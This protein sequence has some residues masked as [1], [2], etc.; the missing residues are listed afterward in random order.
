[1]A[2][3]AE[4]GG[5]ASSASSAAAIALY[6][7]IAADP[8]AAPSW[9]DQALYKKAKC[10][11][12]EG[13]ADAALAALYDVLDAHAGAAAHQEPDFFWFEKAG[14]DAAAMLEARAQWKGAI[15]ILDKLVQ[16]GGPGA[17]EAKKR[18]EQ[19]RLEHFV[20]D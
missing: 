11:D 17:G 3:A 2:G 18:A 9:R 19:L 10:L 1:M 7:Q 12:R 20:W 4:T 16:A 15:S 6:D 14:N 8:E 13:S 5:T